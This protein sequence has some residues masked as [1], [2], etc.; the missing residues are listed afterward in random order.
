MFNIQFNSLNFWREIRKS[1]RL[2]FVRKKEKNYLSDSPLSKEKYICVKKIVYNISIQ[3]Q[4][5]FL[6]QNVNF[7]KVFQIVDTLNKKKI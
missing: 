7:V 3:M 1:I 4:M 2:K 5:F 6:F